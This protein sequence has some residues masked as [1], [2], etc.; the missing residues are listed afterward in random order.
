MRET[1]ASYLVNPATVDRDTLKGRNHF[2]I[3]SLGAEMV[4]AVIENWDQTKDLY[5]FVLEEYEIGYGNST[6]GENLKVLARLIEQSGRKCYMFIG[7]DRADYG[8]SKRYSWLPAKIKYVPMFWMYK[9]YIDMEN[10]QHNY[11][12]DGIINWE[13]EYT[14][15][16]TFCCYNHRSR[17]HRDYLLDELQKHH[18]LNNNDFT[19]HN[20]E[21]EHHHDWKY[22]NPEITYLEGD[23]YV[24]KQPDPD[25]D[26]NWM[27]NQ[28][29]FPP[30]Y[31]ES[32]IH[33]VTE[34]SFTDRFYSEKT[35][36]PIFH[37]KPFIICGSPLQNQRLTD[38]GFKL[39]NFD[40]NFDHITDH[41]ERVKA[42]AKE[43]KRLS[44]IKPEKLYQDNKETAIYNRKLAIEYIKTGKKLPNHLIQLALNCN[45]EEEDVGALGGLRWYLESFNI[46]NN[47]I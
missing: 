2:H 39:Y 15:K 7:R 36:F 10:A 32:A 37:E 41:K 45:H 9:L 44:L 25:L 11:N 28:Y 46:T 3:W 26:T 22:W 29:V 12:S 4:D 40:Y 42:L 16:R 47:N 23:N 30:K 21:S 43:I 35:F 1:R 18:L 33:L 34:T 6:Y 19:W 8:E 14:P 38:F 5:L 20:F 27:F 31:L 17:W 24:V 13:F